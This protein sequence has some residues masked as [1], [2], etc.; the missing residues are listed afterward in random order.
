[1]LPIT[2]TLENL[3]SE[4]QILGIIDLTSIA[5]PD[6]LLL[7]MK[8][9]DL[10][11]EKFE[12]EERIVVLMDKDWYRTNKDCGVLLEGLQRQINIIDI[13]NCFVTIL[14]TNP[15][16]EGE[17]HWISSYVSTDSTSIT[18]VKCSGVYRRLQ[19]AQQNQIDFDSSNLQ[20]QEK[21]VD[22]S[23][24][25]RKLLAQKTFCLAPWTHMTPM[26]G[27]KVRPCCLSDFE[28][29]DISR[30]P[31]ETIWNQAPLR[32]MRR[33]MLADQYHPACKM[34]YDNESVG[35]SSYRHL[36]N[37][38]MIQHMPRVDRTDADGRV[39]EF[40]LNY[41]HFKINN[42]CNLTCR[43]CHPSASSSWHAVAASLGKISKDTPVL[44]NANDDGKLMAEFVKHLPHVDLIRFTGGEP[45]MMPE[46][47]KILEI[48]L[49]QGRTD[50]ELYYHTNLTVTKLK[51]RS[52]FDL[53]RRF[54]KVVVGASLDAE[55]SRG[56][57]LR[58]GSKW[59]DILHNRRSMIEECPDVEFYIS[60]VVTIANA[61]HLPDFHQSWV[62]KGL[63]LPQ[64]FEIQI[65]HEPAYLRL[66]RAPPALK[67]NIKQK[68]LTH[69]EWLR[70]IDPTG[71]STTSFE[72]ILTLLET[73]KE[74]FDHSDFWKNTRE[75]DRYHGVEL[76]SVFPELQCLA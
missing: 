53:W 50:V 18:V 62:E 55:G 16:I 30:D 24:R 43:M 61:W 28:I 5:E 10:Y 49:E 64:D 67:E 26:Q 3:R 65:L 22:L 70:P 71:R 60:P 74:G 12:P 21:I 56:E 63:V 51:N 59:D 54:D 76:L 2:Q 32:E 4:F 23:D 38:K 47:Y 57:Y 72:S 35:K 15:D 44:I 68:Y 69:L 42:L 52:I 8:L 66:H 31:L 75:L 9:T 48:L 46:F 29:G 37:R 14:T 40:Q 39:D 36:I 11:R 7:Q 19:A 34:C 13:S 73:S 45:L 58:G 33:H 27:K 20:H 1:M 6:W 25:H 17:T 41:L